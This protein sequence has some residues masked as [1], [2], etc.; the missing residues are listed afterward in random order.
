MNRPAEVPLAG[1]GTVRVRT[2]SH[3]L[4]TAR[5]R[6]EDKRHAAEA[7]ALHSAMMGADDTFAEGPCDGSSSPAARVPPQVWLHTILQPP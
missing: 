1:S 6:E 7:A 2:V 5:A 4:L 3:D